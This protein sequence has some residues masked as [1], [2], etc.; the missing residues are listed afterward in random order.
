V[1]VEVDTKALDSIAQRLKDKPLFQ[2]AME[3]V[4]KQAVYEYKALAFSDAPNK[5]GKMA[6]SIE[7]VFTGDPKL[8]ADVGILKDGGFLGM[9]KPTVWVY[10]QYVYFGT[11]SSEK[12]IMPTERKCLFFEPS[13]G[14][15]KIFRGSAKHKGQSANPFLHKTYQRNLPEMIKTL[16]DGLE[17]IINMETKV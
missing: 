11:K 8:N 14:G 9:K 15:G 12:P 7:V 4:F 3:P 6:N 13:G 1:K 5:T 10:S 17:E 2:K 16:E